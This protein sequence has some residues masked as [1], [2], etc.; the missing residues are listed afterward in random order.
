MSNKKGGVKTLRLF[1]K[2]YVYL[3]ITNFLVAW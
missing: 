1:E 2:S 3:T